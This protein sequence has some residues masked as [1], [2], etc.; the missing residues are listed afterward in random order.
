VWKPR[1]RAKTA[2]TMSMAN[3]YLRGPATPPREL[4]LKPAV[5]VLHVN[6]LRRGDIAVVQLSLYGIADSHS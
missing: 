1:A 6:Y 3:R 4:M 2:T 5:L